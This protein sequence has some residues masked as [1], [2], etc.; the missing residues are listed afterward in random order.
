[1]NFNEYQQIA[2]YIRP[3]ISK[4]QEEI[5]VLAFDSQIKLISEK[6]LF[7]GTVDQCLFHPRDLFQF[8]ILHNAH[9]YVLVHNH[10]SENCFP[11]QE[12]LLMTK[13]I[14]AMSQVFEIG[15]LDHFIL[16]LTGF[17]SFRKDGVLEKFYQNKNYLRNFKT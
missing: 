6:L 15:L 1:M 7:K 13:K 11:S 4:T 3:K 14:V 8:L 17:Y 10:I 5:W 12:D 16:S 9:Q 2:E